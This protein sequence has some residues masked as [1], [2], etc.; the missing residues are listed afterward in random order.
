MK[1]YSF[2]HEKFY[3]TSNFFSL[4]TWDFDQSVPSEPRSI[5]LDRKRYSSSPL[6]FL[7]KTKRNGT[8]LNLLLPPQSPPHTLSDRSPP[9]S[10]RLYWLSLLLSPCS[11]RALVTMRLSVSPR[12]TV[13]R[14]SDVNS[15]SYNSHDFKNTKFLSQMI[16]VPSSFIRFLKK[17]KVGRSKGTMNQCVMLWTVPTLSDLIQSEERHFSK[18]SVDHPSVKKWNFVGVSLHRYCD[19]TTKSYK[20]PLFLPKKKFLKKL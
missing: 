6:F 2:T 5:P 7:T 10:S 18:S 1:V 16:D 19:F 11:T 8:S 9:P 17:V 4:R 13:T 3:F 20:R 14:Y 15:R 12:G